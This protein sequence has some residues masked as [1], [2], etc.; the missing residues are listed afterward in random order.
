MSAS[1]ANVFEA[2]P[3]ATLVEAGRRVTL[4]GG[5]L[6]SEGRRHRVVH[7]RELTG[8]DEEMLCSRF[9]S[10]AEQ[11]TAFLDRAIDQLEGWQ[12]QAGESLSDR[13]LV[14][15]RDYLLLRLRQVEIGD[16]VH[17]VLRCRERECAKK[18]DVEFEI[19]ELPVRQLDNLSTAFELSLLDEQGVSHLARLR[20][21]TG[22]DLTAVAPLLESSP[23]AANTRLYARLLQSLEGFEVG[24][25][26]AVRR[27]P[28]RLRGQIADFIRRR[29]P[30][31]DLRIE[32][33][34][35]HCGADMAYEF[36]LHGFFLPSER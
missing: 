14:G 24:S 7:L 22:A 10:A 6:D 3:T 12:G 2:A 11:V 13:M 33:G 26:D 4:P 27:L 19:S 30:G 31:P 1:P 8:A 32:V 23:G 20:L 9:A 25:E 5:L 17:Q 28:L 34:C 16:R 21:P 18:V 29:S 36:D 35:P 15:D